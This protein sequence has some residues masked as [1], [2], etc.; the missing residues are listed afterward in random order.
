ML[1]QYSRLM[2]IFDILAAF[3]DLL[4]NV[5]GSFHDIFIVLRLSL[6]SGT[7]CPLP[8][9]HD[10]LH[11]GQYFGENLRVGLIRVYLV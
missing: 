8:D 2:L 4:L 1:G 6:D 5:L 7:I 3:F 9:P 10:V 11:L